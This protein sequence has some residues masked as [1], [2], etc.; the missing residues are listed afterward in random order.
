MR[1]FAAEIG[2]Y[3]DGSDFTR[4]EIP[5]TLSQKSMSTEVITF[6]F[7]TDK[8][9]GTIFQLDGANGNT[10]RASMSGGTY[11]TLNGF[12]SCTMY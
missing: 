3:Y 5:A 2:Y 10:V 1:G 7:A 6:G 4:W 8:P 11:V 9:M 12:S